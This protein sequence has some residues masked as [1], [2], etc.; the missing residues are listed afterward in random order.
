MA[1]DHD[2]ILG[3]NRD[4]ILGRVLRKELGVT[5]PDGFKYCQEYLKEPEDILA[6]RDELRKKKERL[7]KAMKELTDMWL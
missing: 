5:G 4:G 3:L 1:I 7:E 2:L 6:R